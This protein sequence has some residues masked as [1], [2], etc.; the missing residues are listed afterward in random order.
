MR[1][2][3]LFLIAITALLSCKTKVSSPNFTEDME[4]K[5]LQYL[6]GN[7]IKNPKRTESGLLYDISIPG[8]GSQPKKGDVVV[9]NFRGKLL[10]GKEFD[11]TFKPTSGPLTYTVGKMVPGFDEAVMLLKQGGSGTFVVPPYI[12]YGEKTVNNPDGSLMIPPSSILA[13]EIQL[14]E[15]KSATPN[16]TK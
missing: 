1:F 5:M 12:G 14:L 8:N 10:N 16:Q 11:S 15:V 9:I 7:N 6:E 3:L 13:F 2:R 4:K